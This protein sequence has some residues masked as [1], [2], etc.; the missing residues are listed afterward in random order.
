MCPPLHFCYF[1]AHVLRGYFGAPGVLQR[2]GSLRWALWR[3]RGTSE[4]GLSG[5]R[6]LKNHAPQTKVIFLCVRRCTFAT[7]ALMSSGGT[8]ELQGH[9]GGGHLGEPGAPEGQGPMDF[10]H[11]SLNR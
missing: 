9:L 7:L 4:A 11:P 5:V 2:W 8:L 3:A 1:G 10:E 6:N